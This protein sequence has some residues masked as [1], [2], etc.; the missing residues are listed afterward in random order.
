MCVC[1]CLGECP[2]P[3]LQHDE[4]PVVRDV[5]HVESSQEQHHLGVK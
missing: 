5:V 2:C 4:S 3:Y 1:V